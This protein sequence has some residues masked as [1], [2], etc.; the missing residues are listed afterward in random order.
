MWPEHQV[1]A[2]CQHLLEKCLGFRAGIL[3]ELAGRYFAQSGKRC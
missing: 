1:R 2:V 3:T